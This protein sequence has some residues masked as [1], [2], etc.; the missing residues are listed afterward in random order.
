MTPGGR[1]GTRVGLAWAVAASAAG[2]QAPPSPG[3]DTGALRA[4]D[5]PTHTMRAVLVQRHGRLVAEQYFNG[6]TADSLHDIRSA[7]KTITSMLIGI[8]IDQGRIAS[9][10]S[11]LATLLSVP[12]GWQPVT[13]ANVLSM[14]S[15]LDADDNTA[16]SPGNENRMDGHGDWLAFAR[17]IPLARPPGTRW[18]YASLN[19]MLLGAILTEATHQPVPAFAQASLFDPLGIRDVRWTADAAG[20]TSTQGNFRIRAR[21]LVALGQLALDHGV[22]HGRRVISRAWL[23]SATVPRFPTPFAGYDGY[24]YGWWTNTMPVADRRIF[25]YFMSGNGGQ[26][27]Y[28]V[29]SL[30]LVVVVTS[31]GYNQRSAQDRSER[32]LRDYSGCGALGID[33]RCYVYVG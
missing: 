25:Y 24:G 15:G 3:L 16:D 5:D 32:I 20:H 11:R 6:E 30:D 7:T 19:Y 33:L 26:K 29:P 4:A 28:V 9:V 22:W 2:A 18:A 27:V 23:D 14:S 1:W 8:A 12:Q 10:H 13:L 21:D 31:A 17:T